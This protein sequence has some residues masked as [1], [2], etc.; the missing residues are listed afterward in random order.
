[1]DSCSTAFTVGQYTAVVAMILTPIGKGGKGAVFSWSARAA[2][3]MKA[4]GAV[5]GGAK[6]VRADSGMATFPPFGIG[7][8]GGAAGGK[9]PSVNQMN[10]QIQRG[11]A[12][13]RIDR[14][15]AAHTSPSSGVHDPNKVHVH[16]GKGGKDG[17]LNRDGTWRHGNLRITNEERKVLERWGWIVPGD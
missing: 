17:A 1:L 6:A 13:R 11:Q 9:L 2:K 3:T 14:V 16:F 15:D 10:R 7:G 4:G 12:P 8:K 5:A